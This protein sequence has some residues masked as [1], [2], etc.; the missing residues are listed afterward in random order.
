MDHEAKQEQN[1]QEREEELEERRQTADERIE[2]RRLKFMQESQVTDREFKQRLVQNSEEHGQRM[3]HMG[4]EF[5][6]TLLQNMANNAIHHIDS[7]L[8]LL[9][10]YFKINKCS[11]SFIFCYVVY[12]CILQVQ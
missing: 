7:V 1:R 9:Q 5:M 4:M 3:Q 12:F 11:F 2:E 8:L 6:A 10:S